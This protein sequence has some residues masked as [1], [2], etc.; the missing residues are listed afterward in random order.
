LQDEI[1]FNK[2]K[3]PKIH[4]QTRSHRQEKKESKVS[5]NEIKVGIE[6]GLLVHTG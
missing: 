3:L 1:K 5:L 2:A 4:Y 6:S